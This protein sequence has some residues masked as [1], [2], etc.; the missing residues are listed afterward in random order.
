MAS[1]VV[2]VIVAV[3]VRDTAAAAKTIRSTN[4]SSTRYLQLKFM[5]LF[6]RL[7]YRNGLTFP[8][9][10]KENEKESKQHVV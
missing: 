8:H 1:V 5:I 7:T 9:E 6:I 3:D 10:Q 4:K 2:K